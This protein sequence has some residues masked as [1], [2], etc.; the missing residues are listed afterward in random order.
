MKYQVLMVPIVFF[1]SFIGA[2]DVKMCVSY[3]DR[4]GD[5]YG[6][7][8]KTV[9][10][11]C[12]GSVPVGFAVKKGD[13]NDLN[14]YVN[15]GVTERCNGIDDNCDGITDPENSSECNNYYKDMDGD[16]YGV[17]ESKCLCVSE[18]K[19][20]TLERGDCDDSNNKVFPNVKEVCNDLDDNCNGE[21]DEGEDTTGC[22]S[23][24]L[25]SDGDGYGTGD[26]SKCL[27]KPFG[28][29]RADV[30]GDCNDSNPSVYPGAHEYFDR[31]DNNCNGVV[32]ENPGIPGPAKNHHHKKDKK[33]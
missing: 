2:Q 21:I 32:D 1:F 29:Y 15:P 17:D 23:F 28:L 19:F 27:C 4:D 8:E 31:I 3:V 9:D 10:F 6:T 30:T 26:D 33:D 11:Y 12:D 25:D 16:G 7:E 13:C 14:R 24:Y 20:S 22:R 5:G 18:G